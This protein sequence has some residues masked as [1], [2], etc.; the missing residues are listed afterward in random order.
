MDKAK[1]DF[2]FEIVNN[3]GIISEGS[4]G[5]KKELNRVSWNTGDPKYDLR[6]WNESHEKM[7]KGICLT[8]SELRKLKEVIDKEIGFLDQNINREDKII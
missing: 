8:E 7:G 2:K 3:L 6:D 1:K 5:W 4:K